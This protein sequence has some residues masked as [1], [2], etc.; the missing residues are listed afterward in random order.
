M[1]E[2]NL[3]EVMG[4]LFE[5]SQRSNWSRSD[6]DQYESI[7]K[8]ERTAKPRDRADVNYNAETKHEQT[9]ALFRYLSPKNISEDFLQVL[10]KLY[11]LDIESFAECGLKAKS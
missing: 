8:Q 4:A 3:I 2:E 7:H 10:R 11:Y 6:R 9:L 1:L 5:E